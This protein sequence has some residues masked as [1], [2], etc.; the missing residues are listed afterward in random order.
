M[1]PPLANPGSATTS[2]WRIQ[3]YGNEEGGLRSLGTKPPETLEANSFAYLI[4]SVVSNFTRST[5]KRRGSQVGRHG[6]SASV[7]HDQRTVSVVC[8]LRLANGQIPL[9]RLLRDVR[10]K[11]VTSPLVQ[12]GLKGASPVCRGLVNCQGCH[13]EVG[14]VEFELNR[15]SEH[16]VIGG[17]S[18]ELGSAW[19]CW[20][21]TST[22]LPRQL[23]TIISN[24]A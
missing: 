22:I 5:D 10:D 3:D 13:V 16:V 8:T 11:P 24:I 23:Q 12:F 17:P 14:V 6:D 1:V 15:R 9:C 4:A 21:L 2:P 7:S 19:W 18:D 20:Q